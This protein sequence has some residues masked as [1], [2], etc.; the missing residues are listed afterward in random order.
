MMSAKSAT[1][2]LFKIKLFQN[3][4]YDVIT[5]A[6]DVTNTLNQITSRE[7][8]YI[9]DVVISPK[10]GNFSNFIISIL[11]AFDRKKPIF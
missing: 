10:F 11:Q 6:D 2:G 9:T 1:L 5:S 7:S 8:S 4:V 3:K